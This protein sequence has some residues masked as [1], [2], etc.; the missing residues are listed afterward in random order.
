MKRTGPDI[1]DLA[2]FLHSIGW[3]APNDAQF[4]KLAANLEELARL[5]TFV[6]VLDSTHSQEEKSRD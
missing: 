6:Y 3:S 5:V 4:T 2:M 1:Y